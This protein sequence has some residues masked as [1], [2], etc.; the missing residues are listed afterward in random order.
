[1]QCVLWLRNETPET[2]A[3]FIGLAEGTKEFRDTKTGKKTKRPYYDGQI[4]HRGIKDFMIQGG[5]PANI[6]A[7]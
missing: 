3:N 6:F 1:M 7:F 5:C 2:V 4:F